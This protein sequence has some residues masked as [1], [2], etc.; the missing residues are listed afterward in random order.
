MA[1]AVAA[2]G[3]R[4][5]TGFRLATTL[6]FVAGSFFAPPARGRAGAARC[7][8]VVFIVVAESVEVTTRLVMFL[9]G[10]VGHDPLETEFTGLDLE[11]R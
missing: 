5:A 1:V 9:L 11:D 4:R 6:R 10:L 2:A 3:A 7:L 8:A